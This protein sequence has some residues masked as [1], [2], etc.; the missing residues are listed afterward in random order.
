[1]TH[2]FGKTVG[3]E[4][5]EGRDFSQDFPTD[6][7]AVLINEATARFMG[8]PDPVGKTIRW[9]QGN[10]QNLT[11]VGVVKD[12]IASSPFQPVKPAVYLMDYENVNWMDFRLNPDKSVNE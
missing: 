7:S 9:E 8:L 6:S 10:K 11:I 2:E 3:F 12:M 1:M 4:I 5:A